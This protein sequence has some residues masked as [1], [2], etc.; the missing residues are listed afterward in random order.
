L[1]YDREV[2]IVL[3]D[4]TEEVWVEAKSKKVPFKPNEFTSWKVSKSRG[5]GSIHKQFFADLVS[6]YDNVVPLRNVEDFSWRFHSFVAADNKTEG[7]TSSSIAKF[8]LREKLCKSPAGGSAPK[9]AIATA[10]EKLSKIKDKC[11][12]NSLAYIQLQ[13]NLT[14]LKDLVKSDVFEDE[15]KELI[16][17]DIEFDVIGI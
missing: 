4:S 2:D 16:D 12:Q 8:K 5:K 15:F 9:I 13:N 14:M 6:S 11:H 1:K 3:G 10:K 17:T 7:P